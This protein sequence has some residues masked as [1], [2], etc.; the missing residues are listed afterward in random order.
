MKCARCQERDAVGPAEY[1]G[2]SEGALEWL[3]EAHISR[4]RSFVFDGGR[5]KTDTR[6]EEED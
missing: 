1:V 5:R 6:L 2:S 4:L 3:A